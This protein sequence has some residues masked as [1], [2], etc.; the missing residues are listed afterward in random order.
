[1]TQVS[2][3]QFRSNIAGYIEKVRDGQSFI[4]TSHDRERAMLVPCNGGLNGQT[5]KTGKH[6]GRSA[7]AAGS[8]AS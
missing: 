7:K 5:K 2:L 3:S 4:L 8:N 1:M 6:A